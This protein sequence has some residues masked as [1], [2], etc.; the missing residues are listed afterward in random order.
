VLDAANRSFWL[1]LTRQIVGSSA[2]GSNARGT[3]T[4]RGDASTVRLVQTLQ[5]FAI[6]SM[7][8]SRLIEFVSAEGRLMKVIFARQSSRGSSVVPSCPQRASRWTHRWTLGRAGSTLLGLSL[9]AGAWLGCGGSSEDEGSDVPVFSGGNPGMPAATG[10]APSSMPNT[11][12]PCTP[13]SVGCAPNTQEGMTANMPIDQSGNAPVGSAACTPNTASC[14]GTVLTRCDATGVALAPLDCAATG[15]SC[16]Q[17]AGVASCVA[18]ACTPGVVACDGANTIST[19]AADGSGAAI[20]R[21]ADGTLCAGNGNCEAITCEQQELVSFN[22]GEATVYWFGQGTV[23]FGDIACGYGIRP[24][25]LGNGDGDAVVGI[26]N[27]TLFAAM[28]TQNY[29]N[30]GACGSCVEMNYQGR[31]VTVTIVDECP[32][33]SNPTC[34]AGH[35]DLS[36]GAWN[37][38]TNNAP[39]TQIGG[40]NWREVACPT[41]EKVTFQLKEPQ[42]QYWN[43]F[44]VRN[45][46]YPIVKAEVEVTPGNWV[47][48]PRQ[49]YNYFHPPND[50]MGTYRVRVTDINGGVIEEQL[51]LAP[52]LQGGNA[53]FECQ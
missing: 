38:L 7:V 46:R 4:A 41:T 28:N 8:I 14:A 21:C 22:G 11:L 18:P 1:A 6:P 52:G 50:D 48:A 35:I 9:V 43:E 31:S 32:I 15:G 51:E 27:P 33:G 16:G 24:G 25:N 3:I 10:G 42:N 13:G 34:T 40:V 17:V 49:R 20:S 12:V 36:R 53:Q 23:N 45:H 39:G 19:C 2:I 29:A 37:M 47:E 44:L 26:T 5:V 30:A